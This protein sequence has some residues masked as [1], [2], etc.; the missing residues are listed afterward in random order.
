MGGVLA[1]DMR[2]ALNET[3]SF[4]SVTRVVLSLSIRHRFCCGLAHSS[5]VYSPGAQQLDLC[6]RVLKAR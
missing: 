3:V 2:G 1:G 6:Q 4:T 5:C